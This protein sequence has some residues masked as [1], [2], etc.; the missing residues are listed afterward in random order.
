MG[1]LEYFGLTKEEEKENWSKKAQSIAVS[2]LSPESSY[3]NTEYQVVEWIW[4]GEK[5]TGELGAPLSYLPDYNA[6]SFRSW[7]AFTESDLAQILVK[8][9]VNWVIGAGLKLQSEPNES[10]I[11]SEG[12]K[13]DKNLFVKQ[14]EERFRMYAKTN[15][16]SYNQMNNY[17]KIQRLAYF[18][19]IVGGDVL[20]VMRIAENNL[21]TMQ[22]IDGVFVQNP[23]QEEIRQSDDAG[24]K[25]VHGVELDEKGKHVAFYVAKKGGGYEKIKAFGETAGEMAFLLYGTDYR[26]DS[27]R[28]MPL[29]SAVL[30]KM[31][32]LDRY[33]EAVVAG[34][35]ERA[36]V[37]WYFQHDAN[38]TGE[39]PDM[40][41]L[42]NMFNDPT[43]A[44]N[45]DPVNVVDMTRQMTAIRRTYEKEVY[46]L[47]VGASLKKLDS[48]METD[49]EAFTTGNFIYICAAL[50]TPYEVALMK[51][52]NSFS[53]SRMA[54]QSYLQILQIKR[55]LFND[56][57]NNKF[58]N[59]FLDVQILDGKIKADGYFS[60]RNKKD[61]IL[62]QAYKN[63][64]F[65]G[66]GVPQADPSKEVTAVTSQIEANLLTREEG[67]ERLGNKSDFITT[68]DKLSEE[69]KLINEKIPKETPQTAE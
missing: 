39:N 51:Y 18:N 6:L 19:A 60:A 15:D 56:A 59:L 4:D 23:G 40:S 24:H 34:A 10:I 11:S 42:T 28:G 8:A 22:L 66:P 62:L 52:V 43:Q 55:T 33:N 67:I 29:L 65:T 47:P 69:N 68:I 58:F 35:E 46:N 37:P 13:F 50:E 38:S 7:Q 36:K 45:S 12:F 57:F 31:K 53:S 61:V 9:T 14:V 64:R 32:K 54:S 20:C 30:E 27:V 5:T 48:G 25:I 26:I 2:D 17:N 16:S 63:A 41:K 44:E 3:Y 1:L 21:P 49:Q